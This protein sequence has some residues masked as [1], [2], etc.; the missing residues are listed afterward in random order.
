MNIISNEID[1]ISMFDKQGVITPLK[2]KY[3]NT[4]IKVDKVLLTTENRI[5][6]QNALVFRCKSY[7]NDKETIYE[8]KYDRLTCIWYLYKM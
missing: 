8:L 4:V 3:N 1:T 7:I 2:F 5:A 6:G